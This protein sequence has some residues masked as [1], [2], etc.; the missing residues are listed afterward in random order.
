[1]IDSNM[2]NNEIAVCIG[3]NLRA[4]RKVVFP[5]DTQVQMAARLGVGVATYG[6]MERGDTSVS[7]KHYVAAAQILSCSRQFS[8]VYT[9]GDDPHHPSLIAQL[10]SQGKSRVK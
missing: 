1:M 7:L 3:K 4:R 2:D 5:K 6:R 10:I 8:D 9:E